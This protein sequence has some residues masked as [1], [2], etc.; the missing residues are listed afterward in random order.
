MKKLLFLSALATLL[1]LPGCKQEKKLITDLPRKEATPEVI[2]AVD[3]FVHATQTRPVAPDSITLHSIMIL[4]HGEVVYQIWFNGQTAETP[5]P[6][7]S[8]SKT[9]TAVAVGLAINEV[10]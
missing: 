7:F 3:S 8:V 9:F 4:K 1:L 10:K 2:A 6:M 5:H